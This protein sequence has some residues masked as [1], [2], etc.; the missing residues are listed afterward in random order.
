MKIGEIWWKNNEIWWN[1]MKF[2][3]KSLLEESLGLQVTKIGSKGRQQGPKEATR[4]L[5]GGQKGDP[6]RPQGGQGGLIGVLGS[7]FGAIF[8]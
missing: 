5:P 3:E 6:D 7:D 2:Y 8:E 4:R 1:L